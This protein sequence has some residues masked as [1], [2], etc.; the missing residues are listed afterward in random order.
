MMPTF[1]PPDRTFSWMICFFLVLTTAGQF[2][3]AAEGPTRLVKQKTDNIVQELTRPVTKRNVKKLESE[4]RSIL[5]IQELASRALA[6]HWEKRT[7]DEQKE[8]ITL[9]DALMLDGYHDRLGTEK[10]LTSDHAITYKA[11]KVRGDKAIVKSDVRVKKTTKPVDYKLVKT[12]KGWVVYDI[13]ID[14]IGLEETYRE[15]Y[16]EI[17]EDEGWS[18]LIARMKEL[19]AERKGSGKAP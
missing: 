13:V 4:L 6:G 7:P 11:E 9:L 5:D 3:T 14:D 17:I 18:G 12:D 2:A 10:V 1:S 8:F 19:L 15:A 16:V